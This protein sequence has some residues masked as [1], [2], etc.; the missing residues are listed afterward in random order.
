MMQVQRHEFY[1]VRPLFVD[2]EDE[3]MSIDRSANLFIGCVLMLQDLGRQLLV[4]RLRV[5]AEFGP[6][7]DVRRVDVP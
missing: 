2:R 1:S 7:E 4:W 5:A 3:V 6:P